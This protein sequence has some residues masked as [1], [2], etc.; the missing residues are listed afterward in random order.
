MEIAE[1]LKIVCCPE[2]HQALRVADE[3]LIKALNQRI[4]GGGVR[5]KAGKLVEKALETGFVRE[6]GKAIYP[7]QGNLPILLIDEAIEL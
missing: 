1:L 6:D 4:Q 5:N 3:T 2:T 7:V